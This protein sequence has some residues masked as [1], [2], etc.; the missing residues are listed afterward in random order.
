MMSTAVIVLMLVVLLVEAIL[1]ALHCSPDAIIGLVSTAG[2][3]VKEH[4]ADSNRF[5][6]FKIS[7]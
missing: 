2:W 5:A 1:T 3:N 7:P 4:Y 6:P